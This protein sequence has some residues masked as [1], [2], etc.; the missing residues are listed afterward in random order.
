MFWRSDISKDLQIFVIHRSLEERKEKRKQMV[1]KGIKVK[2]EKGKYLYTKYSPS[3]TPCVVRDR[4][5]T[6]GGT[7]RI[8]CVKIIYFSPFSLFSFFYLSIAMC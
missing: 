1:K 4:E 8:F 2:K 7:H 3:P 6:G 5:S